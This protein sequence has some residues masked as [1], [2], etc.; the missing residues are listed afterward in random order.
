MIDC[1]ELITINQAKKMRGGDSIRLK[2][3]PNAFEGPVVVFDGP[4]RLNGVLRIREDED[5]SFRVRGR[6]AG[7]RVRARVRIP[8]RFAELFSAL[9]DVDS[10]GGSAR[11][12]ALGGLLP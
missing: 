12:A 1:V 9:E 3:D 7:R 5:L 8:T 6:I 11:A 10:G 2:K 4:G